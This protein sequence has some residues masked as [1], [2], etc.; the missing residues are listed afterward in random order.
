MF[1]KTIGNIDD[2]DYFLKNSGKGKK[3]PGGPTCVVKGIE[4]LCLV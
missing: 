3:F 2:N 4:M 1:A